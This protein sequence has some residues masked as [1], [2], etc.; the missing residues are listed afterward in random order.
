MGT[1]IDLLK[2]YIIGRL[3]QTS[4]VTWSIQKHATN[5]C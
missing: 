4:L 1:N 5:T 2:L 3:H